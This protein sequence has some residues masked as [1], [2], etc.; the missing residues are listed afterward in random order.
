MKLE[1]L[2]DRYIQNA[3]IALNEVEGRMPKKKTCNKKVFKVLESASRYLEDAQF[4]QTK[5]N[6][7]TAL[8][9][10]AYC[11]GLLDALR[12]LGLVTFQWSPV[13]E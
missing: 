4:Y 2:V 10:V 5:R 9:S 6:F 8:T 13:R 1:V 7:K 3:R 11:E 12:I